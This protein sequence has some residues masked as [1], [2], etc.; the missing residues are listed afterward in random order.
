[1]RRI[2]AAGLFTVL[3]TA[4]SF[5]HISLIK[6]DNDVRGE[7]DNFR[8]E[9]VNGT[10]HV[11]FGR[12]GNIGVSYGVDGL[13]TIDTQFE[14]VAD[15]IK[16]QL[17]TLGSDTPKFVFNTHWHGDHTGGNTVFGTDAIIVAHE[18][19]RE[20]LLSTVNPRNNQ[21]R[22]PISKEGA[23]MITYSKGLSIHFNGEEIKAVHFPKGHTDGDTAVFFTGSNVVHLGDDFFVGRF[24]F[25]DLASGGSVEGLVMNIGKMIQMIPADA[26]IIPGHGPVSTLEDL[27]D[28]HAMLVETTVIV[29]THMTEGKTLDQIKAAGLPEKFKDAGSGFINQDAW[30]ETIYRS[31]SPKM[32]G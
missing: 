13:L 8:L 3:L 9:K 18:N 23:P 16:A 1:M 2:L 11:L 29:R 12:G 30:I 10:V 26:K 20:R 5:A 15:N 17:K 7:Q 24:P 25:V 19:V 31:Y 32:E 21:P 22:E 6:S 27:K 28:Y 14:N 4:Q